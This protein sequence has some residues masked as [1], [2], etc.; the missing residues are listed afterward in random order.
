MITTPPRANDPC[1]IIIAISP[2]GA[3]PRGATFGRVGEGRIP[4]IARDE[5]GNEVQQ[6]HFVVESGEPRPREPIM[7]SMLTLNQE[8]IRQDCLCYLMERY[9]LSQQ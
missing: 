2:N 3:L 6:E 4:V 9:S 7:P 8:V 5:A 1:G